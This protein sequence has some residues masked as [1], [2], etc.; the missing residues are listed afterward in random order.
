MHIH[1]H[2]R[3]ISAQ[4]NGFNFEDKIQSR[5]ETTGIKINREKDVKQI[6]GSH[7]TA[8]DHLF[9]NDNNEILV[10][11]QDKWLSTKVTNKDFNHFS[12]CVN[13]ISTHNKSN[14]YKLILALYV[15]NNGLTM[16][17]QTQLEF[18]NI[19][20]NNKKS[21]I[22]YYNINDTS[23]Q[24]LIDKVQNFIHKYKFYT[25]DS[26]GDCNMLNY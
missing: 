5:L 15:S 20:F 3:M 22:K 18:E 25:Y 7:I 1:I 14:N 6:Y 23:E 13:T 12:T 16:P 8:I 24:R 4:Q 9:E 11:I 17:S 2:I 26:Q 10:C 19:K 21:I